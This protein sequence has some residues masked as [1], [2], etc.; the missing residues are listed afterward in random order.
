MVFAG[1][2]TTRVLKY[3]CEFSIYLPVK[4]KQIN[5]KLVLYDGYNE[6]VIYD[7]EQLLIRYILVLL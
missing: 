1:I 2:P 4:W 5:Y 6:L 3:D 7:V